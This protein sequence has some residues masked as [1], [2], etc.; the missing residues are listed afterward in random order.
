MDPF[1]AENLA[2]RQ[3]SWR[4]VVSQV[5]A[6]TFL[7]SSGIAIV[8]VQGPPWEASACPISIGSGCSAFIHY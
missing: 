5:T 1:F 3:E 6:I 4:R 8:L 7:C 2:E